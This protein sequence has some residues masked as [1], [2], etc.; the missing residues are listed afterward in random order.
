MYLMLGNMKR[1][2]AAKKR[3]K[4]LVESYVSRE[5]NEKHVA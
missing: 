5:Y 1:E 3:E 4:E 2:S